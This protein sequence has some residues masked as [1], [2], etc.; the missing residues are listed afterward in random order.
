MVVGMVG[1]HDP[2]HFFQP[3][4]DKIHSFYLVPIDFHRTLRPE[5]LQQALLP[6]RNP[7]QTIEI[8]SDA[9][10]GFHKALENAGEGDLVLVA[11]SFYLVGE[12]GL[13]L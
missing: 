1:G 2:V 6:I 7:G 5:D 13:K 11:G 10:A 8:F 3:I 9:V 4:I 12:I